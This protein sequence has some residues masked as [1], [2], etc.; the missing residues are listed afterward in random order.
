MVAAEP[1]VVAWPFRD[2]AHK[3]AAFLL[4][5]DGALRREWALTDG[6]S[7][8]KLSTRLKTGRMP[9]NARGCDRAIGI[10]GNEPAH[11]GGLRP[12]VE[13]SPKT[14]VP[15]H[16]S[17]IARFQARRASPIASHHDMPDIVRFVDGRDLIG[18][19]VD[20]HALEAAPANDAISSSTAQLALCEG[21]TR[22]ESANR[23]L[24][25]RGNAR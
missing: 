20:L 14:L 19:M 23:T 11:H 2:F 13:P 9:G 4:S 8:P 21:G 25:P 6:A 18:R 15:G 22:W 5:T 24:V 17:P 3:S 7:A 10:V 1:R 16:V 12:L